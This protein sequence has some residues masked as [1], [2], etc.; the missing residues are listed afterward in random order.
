VTAATY[1]DTP[2]S[3]THIQENKITYVHSHYRYANAYISNLTKVL[4]YQNLQNSASKE[5]AE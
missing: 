2:Y 3:H 4:L 5:K 1:N